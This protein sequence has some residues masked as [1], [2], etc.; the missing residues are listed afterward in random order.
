LLPETKRQSRRQR[1]RVISGGLSRERL[2]PVGRWSLWRSGAA[3]AEPSELSAEFMARQ[4]LRRY[5]VIFRELLARE[6]CAPSWRGILDVCRRLEARGEIRGGRFINGCLGQQFALPEAVDLLR[7]ARRSDKNEAPLIVSAADP[8]NL[9]GIVT[10]GPRVSPYSGQ[11]IAYANGVPTD[12]G[13][14]G[15][16]LSR[17]GQNQLGQKD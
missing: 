16:V 7:A 6:S 1:L 5:G 17:L 4:L 8:L 14:L 10:P 3:A 2:M 15:A 11:V 9:V 13:P 12:I